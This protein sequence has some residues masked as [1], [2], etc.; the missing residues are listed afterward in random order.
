MVQLYRSRIH[1]FPTAANYCGVRNGA[2]LSGLMTLAKLSPL[3]LL[4]VLGVA[5]FAHQPQMIHASEIVSPGWSNWV[6]A[7][8]LL[9]FPFVGWEESLIPTGEVREPRRTIPFALVAGL[10]TC[11][12][13][14]TLLQFITAAT[15]GPNATERPLAQTASVLLGAVERHWYRLPSY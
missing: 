5:H 13:V 8:V 2:N 12:A 7:V 9:M 6:R 4:I 3:A 15:V 10:I 1:R 11:A 14:Y